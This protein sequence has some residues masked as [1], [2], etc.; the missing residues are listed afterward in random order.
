M[1]CNEASLINEKLI[2]VI[3]AMAGDDGGTELGETK[4]SITDS[5]KL[6]HMTY[7]V[8]L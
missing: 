3:R 1:H 2:Y 4:V 7:T 8:L 6:H 5:M